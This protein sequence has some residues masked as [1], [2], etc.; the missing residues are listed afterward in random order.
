MKGSQILLDSL[1]GQRAAA[2]VVDGL[3]SDFLIDPAN[4]DPRPGAIYRATVQRPLKGQGGVILSLPDGKSGFLK[5]IRGAVPGAS[6]LVQVTGYAEPGKAVPVTQRILFKSRYCIVTPDAP[7]RNISRQIKD[8]EA[9]I[10]LRAILEGWE[11]PETFGLILRS[12]AADAPPDDIQDDLDET[13]ALAIAV[14]ADFEGAPELLLDGPGPDMLAWRDWSDV[15]LSDVVDEPGCFE[16]HD[17]ADQIDALAGPRVPLSAGGSLFV[18]PTR[19]LVA[20]DVN[21]GR[22]TSPAAGLKANLDCAKA[23][24]TALRLRGLGGQITVDL[25]PMPKKDR[26]KLEQAFKS[27]FRTDTIDTTVVGFTPLGHLELQRKR[28]RL[29]LASVLSGRTK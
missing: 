27:A 4:D 25:A 24:P 2:L 14:A 10:V 5:Q 20:V 16:S 11:A 18:E 7:G 6:I 29:P 28:E 19:A 15:A 12:C 21:T 17:I 3:L 1:K 23:L 26:A 8:E 13:T 9:R 22:D